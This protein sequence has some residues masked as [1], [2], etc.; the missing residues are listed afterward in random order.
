MQTEDQAAPTEVT[1]PPTTE[2]PEQAHEPADTSTAPGTEQPAAAVEQQ[3]QEKPKNDW[4]QRRID[5]L[6]REKHEEK[7][8][9]EAL[10]ARLRELQPD[11]TT[12]TTQPMTADQIRAE[13]TRLIAQEKFDTACNRVFDAGKTEFPDWDT[14]LRTFQMLG[15]ASQ[16]FLEAVTSMDSG[17]K[18]LH[19][20]G[21]NPE[22]AER[23]LSLPPLRMALELARLETTV[24]QAKPAPVSKAPAPISPVGGKSAPVE[25][26]EF[27]TTADYVAWRRRNRS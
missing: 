25:P 26:A 11:A 20:L 9:R 24:G 4:V 14:S 23:L 8:Q 21:Q 22:E 10:E 2:T 6:T 13:A 12:T 16:D 5:Q 3:P 7:R 1:V 27:A 17:H 15:G 18:V 19:H